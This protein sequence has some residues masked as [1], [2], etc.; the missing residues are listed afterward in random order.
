VSHKEL[1]SLVLGKGGED[2][3]GGACS[4][5][6]SL[7]PFIGVVESQEDTQTP[8]RSGPDADNKA[9]S[10]SSTQQQT[11]PRV[12]ANYFKIATYILARLLA[13]PLPA[14]RSEL[15]AGYGSRAA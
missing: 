14:D 12:S 7:F 5:V 15:P 11:K 1:H 2:R 6:Q 4:Q 3:T 8:L 10:N 9:S 13:P